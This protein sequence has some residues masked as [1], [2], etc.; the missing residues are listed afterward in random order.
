MNNP[1]FF[2]VIPYYPAV[3][4]E[5]ISLLVPAASK[6]PLPLPLSV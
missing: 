2:M 5:D 4:G 6:N 1:G 3:P